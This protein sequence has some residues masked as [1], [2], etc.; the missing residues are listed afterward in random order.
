VALG[1]DTNRLAPMLH[2]VA[3][4]SETELVRQIERAMTLLTPVLTLVLG[5][6]VG[7]IIMSVMQAILGISDI[8]AG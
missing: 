7:G 6:T 5:V 3:R 4:T 1:E 2:H 8:A